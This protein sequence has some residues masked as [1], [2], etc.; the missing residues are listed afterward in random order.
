MY[1]RQ[2]Y[3]ADP[4][5]HERIIGI[6]RFLELD[7]S[8]LRRVQ[9]DI[10]AGRNVNWWDRLSGGEVQRLCLARILYHRPTVAL[11]DEST[12]ALPIEMERKIMTELASHSITIVS[13]GHRESLRQFHHIEL[14]LID[15]DNHKVIDLVKTK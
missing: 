12:S 9:Y 8:L 15:A 7:Q 10:F 14:C 3:E 1:H 4:T 5:F 13:C 2:D 6:L 11:L